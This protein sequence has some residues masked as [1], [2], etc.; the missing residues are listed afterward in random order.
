M[1]TLCHQESD[2][3]SSNMM[4]D[5]GDPVYSQC[6]DKIGDGQLP[7]VSLSTNTVSELVKLE[8]M[9]ITTCEGGTISLDINDVYTSS[10]R[11]IITGTNRVVDALNSK[12]S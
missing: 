10:S 1:T 3:P 12:I 9:D 5:A 2:S 11:A 7:T 8:P 6:V 4:P